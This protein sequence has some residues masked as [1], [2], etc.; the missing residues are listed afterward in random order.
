MRPWLAAKIL[1]KGRDEVDRP[2]QRVANRSAR[3]IG[4]RSRVDDNERRLDR[5]MVKEILLAEP[6]VAKIIAVIRREDG[7]RVARQ[8][9]T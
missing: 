1:D 7:H 5:A 6:V 2:D 8:A 9:A 4:L 3:P